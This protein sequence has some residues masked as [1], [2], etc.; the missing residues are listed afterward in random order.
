MQTAHIKSSRNAYSRPDL[1]IIITPQMQSYSNPL[2]LVWGNVPNARGYENPVYLLDGNLVPVEIARGLSVLSLDRIDVLRSVQ[3]LGVVAPRGVEKQ[4]T[5]NRFTAGTRVSQEPGRQTT[6]A[7]PADVAYNFITRTDNLYNPKLHAAYMDVAGY[8]EP[9][10]Y[11]SPKHTTTLN[12]D[13]KPDLRSTLFW[14]PDIQLSSD[15]PLVL[16]YYNSDVTS[17]IRIVA[18]GITSA[19]VPVT[20]TLVYEVQ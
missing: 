17:T 18:E 1:E 2:Q 19:G 5:E 16:K 7:K 15:T 13:M 20:G 6:Q 8:Y 4:E 14:E 9:R 12:S 11:Y 10:I 3:T